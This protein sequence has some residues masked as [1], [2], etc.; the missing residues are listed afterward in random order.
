MRLFRNLTACA[1]ALTMTLGCEDKP[2]Q[3]KAEAQQAT[4]TPS[5]AAV[6]PPAASAKTAGGTDVSAAIRT[7]LDEYEAV[8]KKLAADDGSGIADAA[9][10]IAST[11]T[12]AEKSA[13]GDA[14]AQLAA[15]GKAA[16]ALGEEKGDIEAV[17]L[18]FGEV[19]KALVAMLAGNDSLREGQ[20]LF[21]CPMAKGYKKWIQPSDKLENPYM[22]K[23]MLTCGG[24][25][26]W[27]V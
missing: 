25:T 12:D 18:A 4:T 15:L 3:P 14:K 23:K 22:G 11:A 1:L 20:H 9:K 17:R 7:V 2:A 6:A 8:R 24:A 26:D 13:S 5:A 16:T 21:E 10:K 27:K 19:S